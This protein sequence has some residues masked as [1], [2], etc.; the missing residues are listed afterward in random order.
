VSL[1]AGGVSAIAAPTQPVPSSVVAIVTQVFP[2]ATVTYSTP[3]S[4]QGHQLDITLGTA[5]PTGSD[6]VQNRF[7]E[8]QTG[9]LAQ[10]ACSR[11]ALADSTITA[12]SVLNPDGTIPSNSYDFLHGSVRATTGTSLL[13]DSSSLGNLTQAEA[14]SQMSSN[15]SVLKSA[16]TPG[17][18]LSDNLST[19]TTG[20]ADG[21][22]ALEVS[23]SVSSAGAVQAELGDFT[24]GLDT[25]LVGGLSTALIDG[26]GVEVTAADGTPVLG[27]WTASLTGFGQLDFGSDSSPPSGLSATVTFPV[28]TGGP[29][30][31]SSGLGQPGR[32]S[33]IG[34]SLEPSHRSGLGQPARWSATGAS[35]EPSHRSNETG[36]FVVVF[37]AGVAVVLVGLATLRKRRARVQ[38]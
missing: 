2:S 1:M 11:A 32:R 5:I 7:A 4:D 9:W 21:D 20:T 34:A 23:V 13:G 31:L 37:T 33:A 3:S 17:T 24:E 6:S 22:F 10:L 8:E 26:V 16:L 29:G 35:L 27:A 15:L 12:Y 19:V 14:Q 36:W 38:S 30:T 18:F 28:L 25:G